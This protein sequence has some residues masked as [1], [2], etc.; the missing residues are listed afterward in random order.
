MPLTSRQTSWSLPDRMP[1]SRRK[2]PRGTPI[3][4]AVPASR[5]PTSL[6]T[7]VS[8]MSRSMRSS[9]SNR[10]AQRVAARRVEH[11]GQRQPVVAGPD[12]RNADGGVDPVE[13]AVVREQRRQAVD[14]S[15]EVGA[16]G[17]GAAAGARRGQGE[18]GAGAGDVEAALQQP[19]PAA[20]DRGRAEGDPAGEEEPPA[21][22]GRALAVPGAEDLAQP[23]RPLRS[24][25][26]GPAC[27]RGRD[28]ARRRGRGAG[29]AVSGTS[30]ASSA[31]IPAP[32]P[33][34]DG[35]MSSRPPAGRVIA[36]TAPR[37]PNSAM[38]R[39]PSRPAAQRDAAR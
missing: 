22:E 8:V 3:Q 17:Q 38:P 23:V 20:G 14:L 36:A 15:G 9:R 12:L 24:S 4:R 31:M 2:A 32:A 11:A 5:P 39:T 6:E 18:V 16:A 10:S 19:A 25:A 7:Q 30:R 35:S 28:S 1:F 21:V 29:G 26:C 33:T 34:I 13:L 27:R 37:A